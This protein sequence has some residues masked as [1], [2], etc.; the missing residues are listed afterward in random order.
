MKYALFSVFD[1][2]EGALLILKFPFL[3]PNC[4]SILGDW[5]TLSLFYALVNTMLLIRVMCASS[6]AFTL[7]VFTCTSLA[8]D[9][10]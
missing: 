2:I 6:A 9:A 10:E 1:F 5:L 7:Y 4:C 8:S 3:T